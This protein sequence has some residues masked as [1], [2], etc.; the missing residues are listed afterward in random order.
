M[1][2]FKLARARSNCYKD[3]DHVGMLIEEATI[4][5]DISP[6]GVK[7]VL[8]T[9]LL[10]LKLLII[11]LV[12]NIVRIVLMMFIKDIMVVMIIVIKIVEFF[13]TCLHHNINERKEIYHG[14]R[15][16]RRKHRRKI[17]LMLRRFVNEC[18]H[19]ILDIISLV[20]DSF[21]SWTPM[22]GMI[23]GY[24]LDPFVGNFL[25]KKVEVCENKKKDGFGVLK[26][27]N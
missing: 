10:M 5:M 3:R 19:D 20:V 26:T 16:P 4:E 9:S 21:S 18:W 13:P 2:Y 1:A 23:P 15:R 11:S 17:I 8:V 27:C 22:W 7:W 25:V 24:F 6:I 12:K 14:V